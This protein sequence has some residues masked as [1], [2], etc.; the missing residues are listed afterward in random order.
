MIMKILRTGCAALVLAVA[1][2]APGL[3]NAAEPGVGNRAV[4]YYQSFLLAPQLSESEFAELASMQRSGQKL[5]ERF[6]DLV[7]KYD[8]QLKLVRAGAASPD[9]CDWGINAADGP[10]TLLPHLA[11][12]KAVAV[13]VRYRTAWSLQNGAQAE[14]RDNLLA[15]VTLARDAGRQ[16]FLIGVL[17]QIAMEAIL[18]DAVAENFGSFTPETLKQIVDGFNAP[19]AA[20]VSMAEIMKDEKASLH[21]WLKDKILQF[22]KDYAGDD[23]KVMRAAQELFGSIAAPESGETNI[24]PTVNRAAGGTSAG[25]LKLLAEEE[26]FYDRMGQVM[27][28]PPSEFAAEAKQLSEDIKLS[29]NPFVALSLPAFQKARTREFKMLV[30][31]AMIQAAAEYKSQGEAG[32]Q[33]V[34][35]PFGQGPFSYRRFMF[36]GVDRGFELRSAFQG[37]G[38]P[39]VLIFVEKPGPAFLIDGPHAGEA[40]K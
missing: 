13:G 12:C 8:T 11:K 24:W 2:I 34:V 1:V 38:F 25:L 17:V 18:C 40:R 21:D 31:R 33:G 39:E 37:S 23:A 15:T 29:S 20:P 19:T 10:A 4:K 14:A 26:S 6:G 35:D 3:T 16:G 28:L 7:S 9:L 36:Q 22:Q 27:A 5:P 30:W 32:L